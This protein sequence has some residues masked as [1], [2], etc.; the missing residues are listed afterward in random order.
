M[1]SPDVPVR[2]GRSVV[3]IQVPRTV[4]SVI[5][6]V[7]TSIGE[8]CHKSLLQFSSVDGFHY[9]RN[10]DVQNTLL[11]NMMEDYMEG[12][13]ESPPSKPSPS[14]ASGLQEGEAPMLQRA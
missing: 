14:H 2:I 8:S 13:E 9:W 1:R 3:Q 5:V 12:G 4:L 10:S 6:R 7:A 11:L